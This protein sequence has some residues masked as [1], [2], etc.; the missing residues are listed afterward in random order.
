[1]LQG[2]KLFVFLNYVIMLLTK[3]YEEEAFVASLVF[4]NANKKTKE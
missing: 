3:K 4:R 1:M 2:Q